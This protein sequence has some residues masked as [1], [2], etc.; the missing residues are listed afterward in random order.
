MDS[1]SCA[2]MRVD[3]HMDAHKQTPKTW[4]PYSRSFFPCS[5]YTEYLM[6]IRNTYFFL[7]HHNSHMKVISSDLSVRCNSSWL[8]KNSHKLNIFS[9]G[10]KARLQCC[11][12]PAGGK[13]RRRLHLP[14]IITAETPTMKWWGCVMEVE[15]KWD[16]NLEERI[17]KSWIQSRCT[18]HSS[19][20]SHSICKQ[21][22]LFSVI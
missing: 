12:W 21:V 7:Y 15:Q 2:W 8:E 1:W 19:C 14:L 13:H 17:S 4:K 5:F 11:F 18:V 3:A 22:L 10:D 9:H 20:L 16:E 6:K